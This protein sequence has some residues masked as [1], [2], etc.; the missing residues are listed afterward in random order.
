MIITDEHVKAFGGNLK[1]RMYDRNVSQSKMAKDLRI[2]KTTISGWINDGRI[3]RAGAM[4]AVCRYL[5]CTRDEL[6]RLPGDTTQSTPQAVQEPAGA[7][8]DAALGL[9]LDALDAAGYGHLRDLVQAAA[10]AD[11]KSL[12]FVTGILQRNQK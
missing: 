2:P 6:F 10:G 12:A 1:A 9:V 11:E 5:N 8:A 7:P 3:P 4:D